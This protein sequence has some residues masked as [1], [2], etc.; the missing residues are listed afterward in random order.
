MIPEGIVN[1]MN[2]DDY[3]LIGGH[4][5]WDASRGYVHVLHKLTL[6]SEHMWTEVVKVVAP[7]TQARNKRASIVMSGSSVATRAATCTDRSFLF[8]LDIA[9]HNIPHVTQQSGT[10]A[11]GYQPAQANQEHGTSPALELGCQDSGMFS[12]TC[13][14]YLVDGSC[15]ESAKNRPERL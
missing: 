14:A 12:L 3:V 9:V 15:P 1:K 4:G 11:R 8:V 10:I 5:C 2:L 13:P 7:P 6:S